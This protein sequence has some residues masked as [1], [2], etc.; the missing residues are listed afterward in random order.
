MSLDLLHRRLVV[1][2][3]LVALAAFAGSA[4]FEPISTVLAALALTLA[5]VWQPDSAV[6]LRLER[7]WLPVAAILVLRSLY[8]VFLV[9]D[10]VVI[11]VVDLLLL[12]LCAEALR[13]LDAPNDARLY[14]LTVALLLASTGTC[15]RQWDTLRD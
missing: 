12:L 7:V 14:S 8:H 3:A 4:G 13:S 5:L 9:G 1:G 2:M 11:P 15:Q 10:D 6:S